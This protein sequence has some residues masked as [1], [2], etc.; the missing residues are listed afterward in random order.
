MRNSKLLFTLL[1]GVFVSLA[2]CNST[3]E[4]TEPDQDSD[5]SEDVLVEETQMEET[6]I[7]YDEPE[8]PFELTDFVVEVIPTDEIDS[9][10]GVGYTYNVENNSD[11]PVRRFEADIRF[12]F[13]DGQSLVRGVTMRNTIMDGEVVGSTIERVYPEPASPIG[14]YRII[15]YSLVDQEGLEYEVDLQL[16]TVEVSHYRLTEVAQDVEF[17]IEDISIEIIP[18]GKI[19]SAGGVEYTYNVE[20]NS[21]IP[22]KRIELDVKMTFENEVSQVRGITIR[23][24]LMNGES[25]GGKERVYPEPTAKIKSYKLIGYELTDRED[26]TYKVD[27][28]LNI[29]EHN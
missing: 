5:R 18:S 27:T 26:N 4:N 7:E 25:I 17:N 3:P 16:E 6:V 2:G 28:Q 10:G 24:T 9:A 8:I 19:D 23:D 29:I 21:T 14:E 13:E 22:L 20:N 1:L 12:E 11:I 15:A